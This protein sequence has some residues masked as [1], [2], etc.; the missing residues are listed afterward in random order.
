M[1]KP[2]ELLFRLL[3]ATW[4][5]MILAQN[6]SPRARVLK[7]FSVVHHQAR[8]SRWE[9]QRPD[10]ALCVK[11][12]LRDHWSLSCD[13]H[14]HTLYTACTA[15]QPWRRGPGTILRCAL[16]ASAPVSL[17][18]F[19]TRCQQSRPKAMVDCPSRFDAAGSPA[20]PADLG[21]DQIGFAREFVPGRAACLCLHAAAWRGHV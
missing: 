20:V 2:A 12:M 19:F 17:A 5:R 11:P 3:V 7:S 14:T 16:H 8:S 15:S 1:N 21:M 9:Q 4:R 13:G 10:W 6:V 18:V